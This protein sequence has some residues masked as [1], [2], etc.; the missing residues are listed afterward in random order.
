MKLV[1]IGNGVAGV[2]TA[3]LIADRDSGHDL[4]IYASEPYP[5]YPRPRLI[6]LLAGKIGLDAMPLYPP[7]WYAQR[8]IRT[9]L[10]HQV[11]QLDPRSSQ[12]ELR[13][14]APARAM[15]GWCWR[16]VRIALCLPLQVPTWRAIHSPDSERRPGDPQSFGGMC[17]GGCLGRR[18]A[19]IGHSRGPAYAWRSRSVWLR[20]CLG[21]C[22]A[23]SMSKGR[24]C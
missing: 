3:R 8:G 13:V 17:V 10:E 7:E 21:F 1:I 23:S 22:L 4:T 14:M 11:V 9:L 12:S 2:T 20:C 18:S 19:W 16:W 24:R 15:T 5:Y 6:D